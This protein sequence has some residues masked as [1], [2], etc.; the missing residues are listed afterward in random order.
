MPRKKGITV[1]QVMTKLEDDDLFTRADIF[2]T[3]PADPN[4]SDE[5][6]GDEVDETFNSLTRRQLEA[7]AMATVKRGQE[8]F[9]IDGKDESEH[10]STF[11][12]NDTE[13][14]P[15]SLS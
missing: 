2:I 9:D 3:P 5:D 6:S 1:H 15:D 14:S 12:E 7:E 10:A 4:C 13:S 11:G 8:R